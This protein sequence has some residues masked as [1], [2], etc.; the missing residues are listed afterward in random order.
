MI[1]FPENICGLIPPVFRQRWRNVVLDCLEEKN[2][3]VWIRLRRELVG[4]LL[5][6]S[7]FDQVGARSAGQG[8]G[9]G[10]DRRLA[11][12]VGRMI[13]NI[14]PDPRSVKVEIRQSDG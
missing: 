11:L 9:A 14:A 5:G 7:L 10:T 8:Q 12:W 3:P 4:R 1:R 6:L 2:P 13:W